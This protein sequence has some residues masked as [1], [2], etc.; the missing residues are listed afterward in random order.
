MKKE[1]C[2]INTS[3]LIKKIKEEKGKAG[4]EKLLDGLRYS[5]EYLK[6][7]NNWISLNDLLEIFDRIKKVYNTKSP[8]LFFKL[9]QEITKTETGALVQIA[10]LAGAIKSIIKSVPEYNRNFNTDQEI[11]VAHLSKQEALIINYFYKEYM[12]IETIDQCEWTRGILSGIPCL[13][14]LPPA[15]LNEI[16][17]CFDLKTVL[18]NDYEYLDLN[19]EQKDNK[20]FINSEEYARWVK[21]I[22]SDVDNKLFLNPT[23][24]P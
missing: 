22:E 17:C 16:T 21:I 24:C 9:G 1:V 19:I 5:E 11:E 18:E 23:S 3:N 7:T 6:D 8:K 20:I 15:E 4:L 10:K 2:C 12:P 14:D 13:F